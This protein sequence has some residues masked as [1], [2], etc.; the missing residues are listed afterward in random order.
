MKTCN[1]GFIF[2]LESVVHRDL[3]D[4]DKDVYPS[5]GSLFSMRVK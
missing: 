1:F 2:I 4:F 3:F 5:P